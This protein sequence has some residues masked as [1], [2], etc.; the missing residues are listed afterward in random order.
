MFATIF[1]FELKRWFKSWVFYVYL[2]VFFG[3]SFMVMASALGVF[4]VVK[5]TTSTLMHMNSP[6]I[7]NSM[8]GGFNSLLYFLFPSIIGASIY[9]DFQYNVHH[10]LYSYPF[11]KTNYLLGKFLSSFLIVLL[12]SLS[13]GLGLYLATFIP[14][15]NEQLIGPSTLW[16][17][18]QPYVLIVIPNMLFTGTIVF[19]LVT[20]SRSIYIGFVGII[21]LFFIQGMMSGLVQ[22]MDNKLIAA[23]IDPTGTRALLYY[24]EYWTIED[25]NSNYLP[26][27]K[28]LLV[29][30]MIWV[31]I[32][33]LFLIIL[34]FL[35][36][37]SQEKTSFGKKNKAERLVKNN[38]GGVFKIDLPKVTYDFSFKS[39]WKNVFAFAKLDFKY[40]AK[41][42]VFLILIGIGVL[43]MVLVSTALSTLYGTPTYPVTSVML[44]V[45]GSTFQFFILIITFLGAGQLV[46]RGSLSRMNLLVDSTVT[47]NWVFFVSKFVALIAV[48]LVLLLVIMVTGVSIQA[49]HGYYNFE[50]GLYLF[51]L[52]GLSWVFYIIWALMSMAVQTLFKNYILGAFFL[53]VMM[54]VWPYIDKLGIENEI[55]FFNDVREPHYSDMN[56][57]GTGVFRYYLYCFYWLLFVGFLGGLTL[58]FWRRGIFS[59]YKDRIY[60]A[61]KN[62]KPTVLVIKILLMVS[63]VG[64]GGLLYYKSSITEEHYSSKQIEE[65]RIEGEKKYKKYESLIQ[66]RIVDVS[67]DFDMYPETNDFL[68]K[69]R[70]TLVNKTETIIDTLIVSYLVDLKNEIDVEGARLV[71]NDT[72]Y[73]YRF[74]A[75]DRA[76]HPKDSVTLKFTVKNKPN[77]LLKNNSPILNNGTFVNNSSF[78]SLGYSDAYEIIDDEIRKKYGLKP[79]E[80]MATQ[81]DKKA[82]QNTYISNDS[83]WISFETTVSTSLDQ[84]AIAPGYLQKEW[85]ENGRRYFH[86]KMDE[87]MLNFYAFNS[88][89][90]EVKKDKWKDVSIEVYYHKGHDY[91]VERMIKGVKRSLEYYSKEF[92]PYQHKQVR[93]VE[94]PNTMGTFAQSFANT[95]PF[96]E[97]IGFIAKVDDKDPKA[98][99]YPFSVTAHEVAHQWWAHQVIGANVQGVTMLSES[100]SEYSSLKVLEHEYGKEQMR[101]FLQEAL[102]G[103]LSG[104]GRENKKEKPLMYNENQ[105]YIHYNKGS[106]VFYTLSDYIGEGK[107]N[108]V[109]KN[110]IQKVAFQEAPYTTSKELVDDLRK[111]TPDSLNYMIKDMF[112][113]ITLYDNYVDK[114]TVK[115]LENGKYEI[116]IKGIISKY[117]SGEKGDRIYTDKEKKSLK[118]ENEKG[119]VIESLPLSDYIEI[120][121]FSSD[122]SENKFSITTADE[123]NIYIPEEKILY[124][125]KVKVTQI[126]NEFVIVVDEKPLEVGI[127]PYN[128]LIDTNSRDNRTRLK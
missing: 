44:F 29:N 9:R 107:L 20:L 33:L 52:V 98:V 48:Q 65:M 2:A 92:S 117:R 123:G 12:I 56:G 89:R 61:K 122:S 37:F 101:K 36:K 19:V 106:L 87:K 94:F 51:S 23:L 43:F 80:R 69:G 82:L 66:P 102:N 95:I 39:N 55:F 3:L 30:R 88:A 77:T 100:L 115:E 5:N 116:K 60:Y 31:G 22:N 71:T 25:I 50:I 54:I 38:F 91:N 28:Y 104:R 120:G 113:T 15:I 79:K 85:T 27:G 35:F 63:F 26:M 72:I 74:Y 111:A 24:T 57:F 16:G 126:D 18:L 49:Y 41:N 34:G 93:I 7:I 78:P 76:L 127:D 128:K 108:E 109:L 84:I 14:W 58:I 86:Y 67:V 99:D 118:F 125:E 97:S 1:S 96:S 68:A 105:Q 21:I 81:D 13:M 119:R 32:A 64:L 17:Y 46:H 75:F 4:D 47:P 110:Y 90:Y 53:L 103:Y 59:G 62:A 124:L 11:T 70:Y 10:I 8:I 45:P 112:E 6:F 42:K 73:G 121:V 83:D 40:L 114:A